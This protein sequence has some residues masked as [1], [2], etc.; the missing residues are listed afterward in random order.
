MKVKKICRLPADPYELGALE[1]WLGD[2]AREGWL[3]EKLSGSHAVFRQGEPQNRR[4]RF[5]PYQKNQT[6]FD[7]PERELFAEMGWEFVT[8]LF[9]GF[10]V[11]STADPAAPELSTDPVIESEAFRA[12][13][14]RLRGMVF[15]ALCGGFT[16]WCARAVMN[17]LM[18]S[19][20]LRELPSFPLMFAG[21]F[22]FLLVMI[23][24]IALDTVLA[25]RSHR[26]IRALRQRLLLGEEI[27]HNAA[28][29][30]TRKWVVLRSIDH[31]VTLLW[32]V[33]TLWAVW[34]PSTTIAQ[35][36]R[37]APAPLLSE[38]EGEGFA[39]GAGYTGRSNQVRSRATLLSEEFCELLQVGEADAGLLWMDSTYIRPRIESFAEPLFDSLVRKTL[40]DETDEM[41][42]GEAAEQPI[43]DARFDE[44]AYYYRQKIYDDGTEGSHLHIIIARRGDQVL[45]AEYSG[46][47]PLAVLLDEI[48]A[49]F[50]RF[51][52]G[53]THV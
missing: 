10:A 11:Y 37:A 35:F 40:K 9:G 12:L 33:V 43:S 50:R 48:D 6:A 30:K 24:M 45:L 42:F 53:E 31:A 51:E 4:Y 20:P 29:G 14:K 3:L 1:H 41:I 17:G 27:D 19:D 25:V 49:A 16:I 38:M 18:Y 5:Y 2:M 15:T 7:H 28:Y 13:E 22:E 39:Y 52:G 34:I 23:V 8:S 47:Q 26:K 36:D 32:I 44:I 46:E 21:L